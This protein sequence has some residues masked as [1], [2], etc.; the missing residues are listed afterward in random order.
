MVGE[1]ERRL[2]GREG[3]NLYGLRIAA[4]QHL[5]RNIMGKLGII[6]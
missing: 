2:G 6:F 5:W 3:R 4:D 1:R